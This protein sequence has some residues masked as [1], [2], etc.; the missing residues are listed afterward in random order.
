MAVCYPIQ[1]LG[2]RIMLSAISALHGQI[3][4]SELNWQLV[5]QKTAKQSIESNQAQPE[6]DLHP[7]EWQIMLEWK[8]K[9]I[10]G[11]TVE[12]KRGFCHDI[13]ILVQEIGLPD[14]EE[15]YF[16]SAEEVTKQTEYIRRQQERDAQRTFGTAA[17]PLADP[18]IKTGEPG[19]GIAAHPLLADSPQHDGIAPEVSNDP[20]I[21]EE[22]T[23]KSKEL[24][25]QNQLQAQPQNNPNM[26]PN[27]G[28]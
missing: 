8:G 12:L 11:G 16:V 15:S 5:P 23:E 20:T 4:Q 28:L 19:Q 7:G 27:A 17:G 18:T 26:T 13:V 25:L 1:S 24:I 6:I 14:N 22:A 21:N 3:I 2:S 10:D 9:E